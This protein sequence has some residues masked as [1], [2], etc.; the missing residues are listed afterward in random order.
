Q[1][2]QRQLVRLHRLDDV[3][4]PFQG[5]FKRHIV[6]GGALGCRCLGWFR[7]EGETRPNCPA[8]PAHLIPIN[9]F[10]FP[11]LFLLAISIVLRSRSRQTPYLKPHTAEEGGTPENSTGL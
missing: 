5:L 9:L 11:T 3:L 10:T 6:A 7:H 8:R 2:F 1:R 4:Q